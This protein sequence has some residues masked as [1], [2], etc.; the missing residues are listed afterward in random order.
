MVPS[1][2]FMGFGNGRSLG[3]LFAIVANGGSIN[4]KRLLSEKA[5]KTLQNTR[6]NKQD[7]YGLKGA[8]GL[9]VYFLKAGKVIEEFNCHH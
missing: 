5:I 8:M 1:S 3:K 7:I 2:S 9:G 4:G 6:F